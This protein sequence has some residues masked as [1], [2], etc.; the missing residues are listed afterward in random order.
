MAKQKP[1]PQVQKLREQNLELAANN[2]K[3]RQ[4]R[5]NLK[6]RSD[7]LRDKANW[8]FN[9]LENSK[10]ENAQLKSKIQVNEKIKGQLKHKDDMIVMMREE[11]ERARKETRDYANSTSWR[12]TAPLR[13]VFQI[14]RR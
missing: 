12:I 3:L 13:A 4:Q 8:L 2:K 5:D 1:R 11:A 7:E 9:Q 10:A 14:F 6:Q